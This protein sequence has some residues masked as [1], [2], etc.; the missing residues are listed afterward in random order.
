MS[1]MSNET[2][3]VVQRVKMYRKKSLEVL[4]SGGGIEELTQVTAMGM[5]LKIEV[6]KEDIL[7]ILEQDVSLEEKSQ[8]IAE[9]LV[10]I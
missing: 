9:R 6:A 5:H 4:S 1:E 3:E 8:L 7:L 10:E 2:W